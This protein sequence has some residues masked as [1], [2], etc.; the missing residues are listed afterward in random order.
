[1]SQNS[2][3]EHTRTSTLSLSRYILL[4]LTHTY[5]LSFSLSFS[6]CIYIFHTH[7]H[8]LSLFLSMYIYF[9]HTHILSLPWPCQIHNKNPAVTSSFNALIVL[10]RFSLNI[11]NI[12]VPLRDTYNTH[13]FYIRIQQDI[14]K[15]EDNVQS[16]TQKAY[17]Q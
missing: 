7:T 10:F 16:E 15:H 8:S 12:P 4:S 2:A 3:H 5:T 9:T 13:I 6:R 17:K 11:R 1:M 14:A